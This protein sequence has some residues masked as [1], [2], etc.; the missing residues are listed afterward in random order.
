M[1]VYLESSAAV[2]LMLREAESVALA[3]FCNELVETATLVTSAITETELRRAAQRSGVPQLTATAI[4]DRLDV[5]DMERGMFTAAGVLPGPQL[6][7][8]DALHVAAALS[9]NAELLVSYDQ[10]Q[11][12]AAASSG[13]RTVSPA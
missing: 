2:K 11:L 4:L 1:I 12:D 5:A 9:L 3:R 7:S 8:L 13:M 6:R 10:R